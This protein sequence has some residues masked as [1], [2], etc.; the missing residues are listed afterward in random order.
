MDTE[1]FLILAEEIAKQH[2]DDEEAVRFLEMC[3]G[4]IK[5]ERDCIDFASRVV[6]H[7]AS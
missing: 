3:N 1:E 2:P 4:T 6:L 5:N 7:H